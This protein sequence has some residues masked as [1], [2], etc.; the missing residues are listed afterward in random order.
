M[1]ITKSP[2][3]RAI[4]S[5]PINPLRLVVPG[6][7]SSAGRRYAN[8]FGNDYRQL[9][10]WGP[11]HETQV[12]HLMAS[13]QPV[14]MQIPSDE[15]VIKY[16]VVNVPLTEAVRVFLQ[17]VPA[18]S[19]DETT[20]R[21]DVGHF[22]IVT[23]DG[24]QRRRDAIEINRRVRWIADHF[25]APIWRDEADPAQR[26]DKLREA[27][28]RYDGT[29]TPPQAG[30]TSDP[31]AAPWLTEAF[32]DEMLTSP[33][34]WI[35]SDGKPVAMA[36]RVDVVGEN[37]DLNDENVLI[38]NIRSKEAS[39]ET[40]LH[41]KA[42]QYMALLGIRNSDG[43]AKYTTTQIARKC[44]VSPGTVYAAIHYSEIIPEIR[45]AVDA[46][47][48]ALKLAITDRDCI[49]YGFDAKG[50]RHL[51]SV[52]QQTAIWEKLCAAFAIEAADDGI[53]DNAHTRRALRGIKAEVLEGT[54]YVLNKPERAD[55]ARARAVADSVE[56]G[57]GGG[58]DALDVTVDSIDADTMKSLSEVA[59]DE[60]DA[61][62]RDD[63][64][65]AAAR[66]DSDSG[67]NSGSKK[68][69]KAE[70]EYSVTSPRPV[71]VRAQLRDYAAKQKI[72][73]D[74]IVLND[75]KR[76]R[77]VALAV[78]VAVADFYTK[79]DSTVFD[80][81]PVL[82]EAL[83]GG[84][85]STVGVTD[86]AD[87]TSNPATAQGIVLAAI[88]KWA[89]I[90]GEANTADV[91]AETAKRNISDY[92]NDNEA[93]AAVLIAAANLLND[94]CQAYGGRRRLHDDIA[95]H[96]REFVADAE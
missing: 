35:D 94:A 87:A 77:A 55:V 62:D 91:S 21:D 65:Y 75:D 67:S 18:A 76:E 74:S 71:D 57:K 63:P 34:T 25:A 52:E 56:A 54:G 4:E 15:P 69:K 42:A 8:T 68:L 36:L 13:A 66:G 29:G 83:R 72:R 80:R 45:A 58:T 14:R 6:D 41:I 73:V 2:R 81:F 22:D 79:A 30:T 12:M 48:I 64:D 47:K 37:V 5:T 27:L 95:V 46:D 59:R 61:E 70:P 40:P 26:L 88:D 28:L 89:T 39:I 50:E 7:S 33:A 11:G 17:S 93:D 16:R 23:D 32:I 86:S 20:N 24:R 19:A 84:A 92:L 51:L 44:G 31:G 96:L 10:D 90:I 85:V 78:A 49:C 60:A 3:A 38:A 43:T 1:S 53:R 82:A 9:I